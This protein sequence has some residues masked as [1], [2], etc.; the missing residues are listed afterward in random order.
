[1][2][3][4]TRAARLWLAIA[5]ATVWLVSVGGEA[6]ETLSAPTLPDLATSLPP[7]PRP[8]QAAHLRLISVFRRG[9][10]L[11]LAALLTQPPLPLGRWVPEPWPTRPPRDQQG[12]SPPLVEWLQA[13]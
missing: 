12:T 1:M 8:H 11:I 6:E 2:T 9:W 3:D 10:N 13:A 7:P 4:P 5:V